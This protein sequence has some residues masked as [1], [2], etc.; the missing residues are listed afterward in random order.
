VET[1]DDE[2]RRARTT[3][4]AQLAIALG[5]RNDAERVDQSV[6]DE[7]DRAVLQ[8]IGRWIPDAPPLKLGVLLQYCVGLRHT[9]HLQSG[10]LVK[11]LLM[12]A[13]VWGT[14]EYGEFLD[15]FVLAIRGRPDVLTGTLGSDRTSAFASCLRERTMLDV[16][17]VTSMDRP[18]RWVYPYGSLGYAFAEIQSLHD[19]WRGHGSVGAARCIA[20]WALTLTTHDVHNPLFMDKPPRQPWDHLGTRLSWLLENV[21]AMAQVL[22]PNVLVPWLD[23]AIERLPQDERWIAAEAKALLARRD[24]AFAS[25]RNDIIRNLQTTSDG[26]WSQDYGMRQ[27][28]DPT[29]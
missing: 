23:E 20:S 1:I 2:G 29:Q 13:E 27:D 21:D 5:A 9:I 12:T 17:S 24:A 25:R 8:E 10:L 3:L 15:Q 19:A 4:I 16:T 22:D 28:T 11:V 7:D 26:C 18:D 6:I 14:E